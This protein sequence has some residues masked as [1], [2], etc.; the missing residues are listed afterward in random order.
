MENAGAPVG[1]EFGLAA[2]LSQNPLPTL[3]CA[4]KPNVFRTR[5]GDAPGGFPPYLLLRVRNGLLAAHPF[6]TDFTV[7]VDDRS[8]TARHGDVEISDGGFKFR[9]PDP[10]AAF[11]PAFDLENPHVAPSDADVSERNAERFLPIDLCG[12]GERD[13]RSSQKRKNC[14]QFDYVS[15]V[16]H[17][18]LQI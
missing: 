16:D 8:G 13:G 2:V 15:T 14:E 11:F 5:T 18:A 12:G 9:L 4:A 6:L 3:A 17:D 7:G 1:F 10:D